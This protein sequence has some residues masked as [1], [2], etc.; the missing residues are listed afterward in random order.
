MKHGWIIA[1]LMCVFALSRLWTEAA[2]ETKIP[3]TQ[4]F[5]AMHT[6]APTA[7]ERYRIQRDA[8]RVQELEA[9]AVLAENN[10]QAHV[11]M[12]EL[13]AKNETE[14]AVESLL[15]S[16]GMTEAVCALQGN[17][18]TVYVPV[19]LDEKA[20]QRLLYLCAQTANM[21]VQKVFLLDEN[22]YL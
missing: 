15:F 13:I 20:A 1:V 16:Q 22:G 19:R 12:Q 10:E 5:A 7:V 11:Y 6:Q 18:L 17:R 9:L 4:V 2:Q 3:V 8:Q 14:L 21:D